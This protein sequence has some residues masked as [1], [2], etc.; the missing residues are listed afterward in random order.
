MGV[1]YLQ[2]T[3]VILL[4]GMENHQ[5]GGANLLGGGGRPPSKGGPPQVAEGFQEEAK[6]E[7]WLEAQVCLLV[8]LSQVPLGTHGTHYGIHH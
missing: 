2:E 5:E 7:I 6:V 1:G 8:F 3:M 4:M